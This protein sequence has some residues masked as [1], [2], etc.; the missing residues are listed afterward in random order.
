MGNLCVSLCLLMAAEIP[1]IAADDSGPRVSDNQIIARAKLPR[2]DVA[3]I[4][5][6]VN[7]TLVPVTVMD[8]LGRNVLGLSQDN[9]RVFD[10]TEQRPIVSFGMSDAPLSI[11]LI[12]DCSR[13]M[14]DKFK[15]AR[16][17]PRQLFEKLN[18][19]DEAFLVTVSNK[20]ELRRDFTSRF[21]DITDSLMFIAPKGTTSLVD[22][23]YMG[24]QR[25]KKSHNRRR[26]LIVVSDGGDNNSRYNM[27]ELT[28]LAAEADAQIFT[29]CLYGN[30]KSKEEAE[31]PALLEHL[32]LA[33]GGIHFMIGDLNNMNTA[34]GQI[35]VTLHHE[36]MLGY[37]P[38]DDAPSGKYRK[39]KV[40]LLVPKGIPGLQIFARSGYYVP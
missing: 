6:N 1:S 16:E 32:A 35:G 36:Y 27:R 5:V 38:A 25:L 4:R 10:G 13:S 20:P 7:M 26:A 29:I 14:T 28:S 11:G 18:P 31:G 3:D 23:V 37:Y 34:M 30:P 21:E 9:F 2:T 12:Y 40:E 17:A 22:G 15:V 19:E 24:L 33:S 39:I 8:T